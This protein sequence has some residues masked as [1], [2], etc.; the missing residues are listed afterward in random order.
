MSEAR[1]RL[2][3]A[4]ELPANTR[5]A[6]AEWRASAAD[7]QFLR[8]LAADS[9]H[10][11]LCFL[12]WWAEAEVPQIAAACDVVSSQSSVELRLGQA[13]WLPRREPR[14][15]AV[16]L[17][18]IDQR[19]SVVQDLLAKRLQA[20]GWYVPERRRFLAHVTVARVRRGQTPVARELSQPPPASLTGERVTLFRSALS[21]TGAQYDALHTVTLAA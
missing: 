11:T 8:P 6:L 13:L 3:V 16:A 14:V 20:G 12:G 1:L 2:F 15:L 5:S 7:E 4:L 17:E 19:L 10:V 21:P 18:E 9:L